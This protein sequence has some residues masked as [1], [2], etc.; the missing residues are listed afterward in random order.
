MSAM[1]KQINEVGWWSSKASTRDELPWECF[2]DDDVAENLS[3]VPPSAILHVRAVHCAAIR[4]DRGQPTVRIVLDC[5]EGVY[6]RDSYDFIRQLQMMLDWSGPVEAW[7]PIK[8][9]HPDR[10]YKRYRILPQG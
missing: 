6:S 5:Q 2:W 9:G 7:P 1:R 3:K 8:I 4:G 10:R